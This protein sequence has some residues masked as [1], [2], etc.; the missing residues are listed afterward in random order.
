MSESVMESLSCAVTTTTQKCPHHSHV[1]YLSN[2]WYFKF[3][4]NITVPLENVTMF[5]NMSMQMKVLYVL[6]TD[7]INRFLFFK[8]VSGLNC[9]LIGTRCIKALIFANTY[10]NES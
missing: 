4:C 7:F 3:K 1:V 5:L 6:D 8:C 9:L 2:I 10:E